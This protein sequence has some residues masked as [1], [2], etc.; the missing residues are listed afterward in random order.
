MSCGCG[1]IRREPP[2]LVADADRERLG[3]QRRRACGRRTRRRSPGDSRG[4]SKPTSGTSRHSAARSA[5]S[6][7]I[8]ML[9]TPRAIGRPAA[10]RGTRAAAPW[11]PPRAGP[12]G[13]RPRSARA[14]GRAA[15]SRRGSASR[16]RSA[17]ARAAGRRSRIVPT[18]PGGELRALLPAAA[19]SGA[20]SAPPPL[21]PPR[22][23]LVPARHRF[24]PASSPG[25]RRSM[26]SFSATALLCSR[27][28]AAKT[29]V[30]RPA[31]ACAAELSIAS[32]RAAS[33][34]K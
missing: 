6:A 28:L 29:R 33:S 1:W 2:E 9:Q 21:A 19:R 25:S 11:R 34:S 27:S 31:R 5:T 20:R 15:R 8:G 17:R 18:D 4:S 10:R 26:Y 12:P 13:R 32:A 3:A 24:L 14:P 16:S 30:T 23:D 22:P 7:G